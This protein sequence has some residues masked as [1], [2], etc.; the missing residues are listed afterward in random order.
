MIKL[1]CKT[2]GQKFNVEEKYSG[3]KVKCPK[4]SSVIIIPDN[5]DRISFHCENCG[6]KIKVSKS[7]AGK[8][9]KCPKCNNIV[10]IPTP[11]PIPAKSPGPSAPIPPNI[12]EDFY[13]EQ[14]EEYEESEGM[15]RR[16]I[17]IISG[18]AAVV[19]VGL[20]ILAVVHRSSGPSPVFWSPAAVAGLSRLNGAGNFPPHRSPF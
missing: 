14:S 13:E 11:E 3:K 4:C 7:Y 10:I 9:G 8:K 18:V 17:Y 12:N 6:Q 2:C 20:I 16:L 15:D 19:V 1:S 5:S